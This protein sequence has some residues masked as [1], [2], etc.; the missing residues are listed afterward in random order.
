MF[1][2]TLEAWSTVCQNAMSIPWATVTLPRASS[3]TAALL[4]VTSMAAKVRQASISCS[5]LLYEASSIRHI[6]A[7]HRCNASSMTSA[8]VALAC[9]VV[10]EDRFEVCN[11]FLGLCRKVCGDAPCKMASSSALCAVMASTMMGTT[12][13]ATTTSIEAGSSTD[14]CASRMCRSRSSS[15]LCVRLSSKLVCVLR[16]RNKSTFSPQL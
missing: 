15:G 4:L 10:V 1:D 2:H 13:T 5:R 8:E 9:A 12:S 14:A 11:F 6:W 7:C 16:G 3:P